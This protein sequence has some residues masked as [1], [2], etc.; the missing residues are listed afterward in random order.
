MFK[1]ET[2]DIDQHFEE[3]IEKAVALL[4]ADEVVAFPTETVYGLGANAFSESAVAKVFKAKGRPEDNPLIVHVSGIAHAEELGE[5]GELAK[6]LMQA[7]WPGPFTAVV[8]KKA[9]IPDIVT[10]GL[11]T[12]GLRMPKSQGILE[13]IKRTGF[14]IAAPSANLSGSPSPT[15][16]FH[17][18]T[19][20]SGRIPLILDG[21]HTEYGLES[22][23]C[24]VTGEI[25]LV[26]RPGAVTAEQIKEVAGRVEIA[27]S[28]LLP[29]IGDEQ[30]T[31][32]GMKYTHYSPRAEV[33]VVK[34]PKESTVAEIR[35]MCG[36]TC[37]KGG[38]PIVLCTAMDA[39]F[40][41][42]IDVLAQG[43]DVNEV[44]RTLFKNLRDADAK[45]Y[46]TVYFQ[47]VPETGIGL[48]VMNRIIRAAGFKLILVK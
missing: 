28:V 9:G 14:P 2:I 37:E 16:A 12:I 22:T 43:K 42:G 23:V 45:G 32:P 17:V 36:K 39:R 34:G 47:A 38:R 46:T 19:D 5:V 29:L 27:S 13:I 24:D 7:F 48:A 11:H 6:T 4:C 8:Q 26:L 20:M 15:E 35:R 18:E 3:G 33:I 44:A 30:I 41:D 1:T 25:P 21:G 40:F 31:S 10:G